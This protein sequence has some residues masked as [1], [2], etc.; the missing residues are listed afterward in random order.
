MKFLGLFGITVVTS[1]VRPP[2][3]QMI[4]EERETVIVKCGSGVCMC[5]LVDA[6]NVVLGHF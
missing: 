2:F 5:M 3:R 1:S 6:V 4:F